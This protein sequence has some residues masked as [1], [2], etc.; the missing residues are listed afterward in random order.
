MRFLPSRMALNAL[1]IDQPYNSIVV[2]KMIENLEEDSM[3]YRKK[4]LSHFLH[5]FRRLRLLWFHIEIP[6]WSRTK[7]STRQTVFKLHFL[8]DE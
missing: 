5:F 8:K 2:S 6:W 3:F 1:V 7:K 4:K